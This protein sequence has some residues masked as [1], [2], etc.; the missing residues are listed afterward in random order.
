MSVNCLDSEVS[1]GDRSRLFHVLISQRAVTRRASG[2][3]GINTREEHAVLLYLVCLL[4]LLDEDGQ[5]LLQGPDDVRR[6]LVG[7]TKQRHDGRALTSGPGRHKNTHMNKE[8]FF[9]SFPQQFMTDF[10]PESEKLG[11]ASEHFCDI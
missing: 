7:F 9:S 6:T 1:G 3:R 5:V 8:R 4:V 2:H 10:F 11:S